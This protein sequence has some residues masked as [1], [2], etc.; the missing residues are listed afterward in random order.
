MK[1]RNTQITFNKKAMA[2]IFFSL[3]KHIKTESQIFVWIQMDMAQ[4]VNFETT[5]TLLLYITVLI[6]LFPLRPAAY[7]LTFHQD[8]LVYH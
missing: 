5:Q 7:F 8:R 6:L 2:H 1:E 3:P 4:I